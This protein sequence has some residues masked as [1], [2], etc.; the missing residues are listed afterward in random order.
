MDFATLEPSVFDNPYMSDSSG[1]G[2]I[3]GNDGGVMEAAVRTMHHAINGT[4]LDPVERAGVARVRRRAQRDARPRRRDRHREGGDGARGQAPR[5]RS[6]KPVLAGG[7]LRLHRDHGLSSGCVDGGGT[8][9][10]KK[11]YLPHALKRRETLFGIDR[12]RPRRQSHANPQVQALY[13]DFLERPYSEKG[14]L[15]AARGTRTAVA[16][17]ADGP[18]HL[19]RHHDDARFT[20]APPSGDRASP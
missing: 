4:E 10:S 17:D 13:R 16:D 6:S 12:A 19:E 20:A 18:G 2:V 7:G 9:R 11:A 14:A 5:A 3:F 15:P 1:A 8:L